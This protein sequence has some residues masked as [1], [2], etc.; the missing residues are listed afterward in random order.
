MHLGELCRRAQPDDRSDGGHQQ[1]Q[2]QKRDRDPAR[3][4]TPATI[5]DQP[6][7][8]NHAQEPDG[9]DEDQARASIFSP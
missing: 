7:T 9:E 4:P 3:K 8:E 6:C 1:T 5:G 2:H